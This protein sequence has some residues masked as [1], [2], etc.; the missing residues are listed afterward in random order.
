VHQPPLAWQIQ[1]HQLSHIFF[2]FHILISSFIIRLIPVDVTFVSLLHISISILSVLASQFVA[3]RPFTYTIPS[4]RTLSGKS[5]PAV[6]QFTLVAL[7]SLVAVTFASPI[8]LPDRLD[9][10]FFIPSIFCPCTLYA[11]ASRSV[12]RSRLWIAMDMGLPH[13]HKTPRCFLVHLTNRPTSDPK[14]IHLK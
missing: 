1:I 11:P 3:G 10:T 12:V 6:M 2:P 14:T 4:L 9:G 7:L 13:I 8:A 5:I